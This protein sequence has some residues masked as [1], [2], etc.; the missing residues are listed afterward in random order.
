MKKYLIFWLVFT[1]SFGIRAQEKHTKKQDSLIIPQELTEVILIGKNSNKHHLEN[2]SLATI[3]TYLEEANAVD[4]I[5][6]GAYAWE[7]MIQGMA[8]ERSVV[9]IDGMRIYAACTDKMDPI[10]SYVEIS[11]LAKAEIKKGQAGAEN[12][13]TIGGA[14]DLERQKSEFENTGW[15]GNAQSGIESINE[16]KI[17]GAGLQYASNKVFT[18]IDFMYRDAE[19]YKAGGDKE[20]NYSQFT[21]Y[22]FSATSGFKLKENKSIEASFIF[23]EAQDV[24][25]PALP[26]DVSLARAYIG[27]LEYITNYKYG[28]FNEWR[29]KIYYNDVTHIM[30]D[31]QR[32]DVPIRMDMPGWSKTA[33]MYSKLKGTTKKHT[34]DLSLNGH[35][36]KSLAEMTMFPEDPNEKDMFMLTWPDVNTI[37]TGFFGKDLYQIKKEFSAEISLGM[38]VH[39][40]NIQN[41]FGLESLRIFYPEMEDSNTRFLL[42]TG[43]QLNFSTHPW[44]LSIGLGYGERAPSVSEAYGFYLFNSFDGFD[45]IGNPNMRNEKSS[46]I[47]ISTQYEHKSF[48]LSFNSSL[49]HIS[50]YIIGKPDPSL[51]PMNIGINGVKVYEQLAHAKLWSNDMQVTYSFLKDF[52]AKVKAVYRLGRDDSN[53]NLPLVQPFTFEAGL[54][55]RKNSFY[56]EAS[57]ESA[58]KQFDYS[59][60]FGENQTPAYSVVNLALS[61]ILYVNTQ[62][63]VLKVGGENLF[64]EYYS[65]YSDWNNIPRPGRNLYANL[66][67]SF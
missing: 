12:G 52:T 66:I 46:E 25:Y 8:S 13:A 24:G 65:T 10:T 23:D 51:S 16:Q 35:F 61:K 14:I 42:N 54:R 58:T 44:T 7:P 64:D 20:I 39:N 55:Y 5:K 47:N 28:F 32:P 11:N 29:T 17:L 3:E 9:T 2:K 43:A 59:P 57:I 27:S 15:S 4:F 22:N 1:F 36:N 60:E 48:S 30:D 45:Y 21:K 49:Y 33:G 40:N 56:A 34:W 50:D 26:M 41:E 37:Y 31:S 67:Y 38:G 18:D 63:M 53:T 62:K 6:R 19:N